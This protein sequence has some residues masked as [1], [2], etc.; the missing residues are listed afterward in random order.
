MKPVWRIII[1]VLETVLDV[2]RSIFDNPD[3]PALNG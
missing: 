2:V 3:T 1:A